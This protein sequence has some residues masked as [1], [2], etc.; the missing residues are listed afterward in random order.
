MDLAKLVRQLVSQ[1]MR[2]YKSIVVNMTEVINTISAQHLK[3][4]ISIVD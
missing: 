1:R 4:I 3:E 2:R